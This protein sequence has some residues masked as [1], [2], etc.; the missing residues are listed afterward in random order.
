MI[1]M[2]IKI[3]TTTYVNTEG[4]LMHSFS[5]RFNQ[6]TEMACFSKSNSLK[7]MVF[8][9]E[10]RGFMRDLTE[11]ECFKSLNDHQTCRVFQ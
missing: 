1:K 4:N 3:M 11:K 5:Y 6:T 9:N 7:N 2:I 8:M 10:N